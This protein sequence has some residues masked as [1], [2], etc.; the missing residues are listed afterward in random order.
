MRG[1]GNIITGMGGRGM[2]R[3][4]ILLN[5]MLEKALTEYTAFVSLEHD[6]G[7]ESI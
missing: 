1:S 3:I 4:G 5:G 6:V 2:V 7:V